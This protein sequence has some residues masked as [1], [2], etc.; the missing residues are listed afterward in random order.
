MTLEA[1]HIR[2]AVRSTNDSGNIL[3]LTG[4]IRDFYAPKT[5]KQ[6]THIVI[7]D[8]VMTTESLGIHSDANTIVLEEVDTKTIDE[9][10]AKFT[11]MSE[12]QGW[13]CAEIGLERNRSKF[14]RIAFVSEHFSD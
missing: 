10:E 8:Y 1:F 4:R 5:V 7:T 14:N 13:G 12:Y 2:N 9:I 6:K 3:T 11:A